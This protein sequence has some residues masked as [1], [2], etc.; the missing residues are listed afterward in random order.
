MDP[1]KATPRHIIIKMT[2]IKDEERILKATRERQLVTYKGYPIKMSADFSTETFQA[3]S[4]GHEIFK[5]N[6]SKATFP[7]KATI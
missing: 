7:S 1:K 6:K 4:D 2:K 3:R 5:V